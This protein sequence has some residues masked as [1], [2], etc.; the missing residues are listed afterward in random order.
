[1]K[2]IIWCA[3]LLVVSVSGAFASEVVRV[4]QG[5]TTERGWPALEQQLKA[6][7]YLKDGVIDTAALAYIASQ[8]AKASSEVKEDPAVF[9]KANGLGPTITV[10]EFK[11]VGQG[12]GFY[13][14]P[15]T[16][17]VAAA[18]APPATPAVKLESVTEER[19]Q[20]ALR[21]QEAN[22]IA[23]LDSQA[24][25]IAGALGQL[26]AKEVQIA[27]LERELQA[28]KVAGKQVTALAK[29][30]EGAKADLAALRQYVPEAAQSA[31]ALAVKP[32]AKDVSSLKSDVAKVKGALIFEYGNWIYLGAAAAL[33]VALIA[34]GVG[35]VNG[36]KAKRA[37]IVANEAKTENHR[38]KEIVKGL[39]SE[40]AEVNE[41]VTAVAEQA[42]LQVKDVKL[43]RD[44]LLGDLNALPIGGTCTHE[45]ETMLLDGR[46][47]AFEVTFT[48]QEGDYVT[49][50]G[51]RDQ[52]QPLKIANVPVRLKRAGFKGQLLKVVG[53]DGE[54][55]EPI[56]KAA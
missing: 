17:T 27:R 55:G 10:A 36:R 47:V 26:K 12:K 30:L 21:Q 14:N 41:R 3:L 19:L 11:A 2:K 20:A 40:V 8:H 24:K 7:G 13:L 34:L 28:A 46:T 37:L 16:P 54:D 50:E 35:V 33:I 6:G 31:V 22:T 43:M 18:S 1:M 48:R 56:L 52:T 51:V 42:G 38:T 44:V 49:V 4:F 15:P 39:T 23:S 5:A 25:I 32:V 45:V 53:V 29:S 9:L